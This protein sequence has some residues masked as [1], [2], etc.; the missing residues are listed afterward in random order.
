MLDKPQAQKICFEV[1]LIMEKQSKWSNLKGKL[2]EES[3]RFVMCIALV[4]S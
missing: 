2:S 3:Y 4:I 1:G